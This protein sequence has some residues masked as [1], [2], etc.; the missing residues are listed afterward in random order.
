MG[1]TGDSVL[2]TRKTMADGYRRDDPA[3]QPRFGRG[4]ASPSEV[5][6]GDE[7]VTLQGKAWHSEPKEPSA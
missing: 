5:A 3:R 4:D 1:M 6:L 7:I 2:G